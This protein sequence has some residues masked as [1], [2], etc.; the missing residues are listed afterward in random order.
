MWSRFG[1]GSSTHAR[2]RST[3]LLLV[4]VALGGRLSPSDHPRRAPRRR[5][6]R[7]GADAPCTTPRTIHVAPGGGVAA[8]GGVTL[9]P[10][11][12]RGGVATT[13]RNPSRKNLRAASPPEMGT[14]ELLQA[15]L[16]SFSDHASTL[17]SSSCFERQRLRYLR[18][19]ALAADDPR[20][21]RGAAATRPPTIQVVGRSESRGLR[22]PERGRGVVLHLALDRLARAA[23]VLAHERRRRVVAVLA[24]H[25]RQLEA[26]LAHGVVRGAPH[27]LVA[28]VDV[29][30]AFFACGYPDRSAAGAS[31][32]AARNGFSVPRPLFGDF[33]SGGPRIGAAGPR[34]RGGGSLF[35]LL[36]FSARGAR[37]SG[38][39]RASA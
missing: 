7:G 36:G 22:T 3:S 18:P 17:P 12:L 34:R 35:G 30:D 39:R 38:R 15:A 26:D 1:A 8:G 32:A 10:P 6:D 9:P 24:R 33:L 27:L 19:G 21:G 23:D 5:R 2:S 20:R 16:S 31:A 28:A 14:P 4:P 25:A 11:T 37:R 13:F 29:D